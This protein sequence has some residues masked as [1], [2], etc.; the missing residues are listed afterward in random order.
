MRVVKGRGTAVF[1]TQGDAMPYYKICSSPNCDYADIL[2]NDEIACIP[3]ANANGEPPAESVV[4]S[5][6]VDRSCVKCK[7]PMLLFC[8]HCKRGLFD[9]PDVAFCASCEHK[10]K[11]EQE[12]IS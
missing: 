4:I 12:D 11:S 5:E 3:D 8:P 6:F 7:S 1:M 2:H 10:I 9:K